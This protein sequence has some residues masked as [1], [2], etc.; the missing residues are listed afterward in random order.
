MANVVV[1][2]KAVLEGIAMTFDVILYPLPQTAKMTQNW[3]EELIKDQHG[4]TNVWLARDEHHLLDLG[5]KIIGDTHAHA[6]SGAAFLSPLSTVTI[7]GAD[8]AS[9]NTT[10]QLV[11]GGDIDL[12]NT[13]VGD[14]TFKLRKYADATQ[15]GLAVTTPT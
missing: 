9:W 7:S 12:A 3:D 1:K 11:N 8:P 10:Y 13:K 2:G 5:M 14:I 6:L 15:N 4:Y